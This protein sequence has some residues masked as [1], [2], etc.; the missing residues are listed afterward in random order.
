MKMKIIL[1]YKFW[2]QSLIAL[3]QIRY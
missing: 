2:I 3:I 1:I